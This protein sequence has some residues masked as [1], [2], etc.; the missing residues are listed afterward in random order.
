[1]FF[2][3]SLS[4]CAPTDTSCFLRFVPHCPHLDIL[5]ACWFAGLRSL[6]YLL[7]SSPF[8]PRGA[9]AR[10]LPFTVIDRTALVPHFT[11]L[12]RMSPHFRCWLWL[13]GAFLI[14][15]SGTAFRVGRVRGPGLCPSPPVRSFRPGLPLPR[16]WLLAFFS[17]EF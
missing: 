15:C 12:P 5:W 8:L 10:A 14:L 17:A 1:M 2:C 11:F 13:L 3:C 9:M 6:G 16:S 7:T 4:L